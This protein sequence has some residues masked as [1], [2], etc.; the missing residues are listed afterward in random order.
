[1]EKICIVKRRKK[2]THELRNQSDISTDTAM[3]SNHNLSV[4]SSRMIPH[5]RDCE[6]WYEHSE[7]DNNEIITFPLTPEQSNLFQSSM[8][9]QNISHEFPSNAALD[10][11]QHRD[12][13]IS[14]NFYFEA[15]HALRLLKPTHVC[16]MLQVSKSYLRKLVKTR[17]MRSYKMGR[18]RRFLLDD[19][20]EYLAQTEEFGD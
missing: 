8:F 4:I 2:Y 19:V 16:Q 17:R 10:V 14:L 6:S 15:V 7:E 18:L 12:G 20:I 1:M 9:M 5:E 3:L 13:R 11:E